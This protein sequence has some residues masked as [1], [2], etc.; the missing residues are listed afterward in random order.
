MVDVVK[1]KMQ[2]FMSHFDTEINVTE[3][4]SN[5]C[6]YNDSGKSA[7]LK[8]L[9]ILM[10][11][12]YPTNQGKFIKFGHD[13]FKISVDFTTGVTISKTKFINGQNLWEM[14]QNGNMIYT[15]RVN[16]AIVAVSGVPK[17]IADYWGVMKDETTQELLNV[18]TKHDKLFLVS[19][20]GGDNYKVLTSK[21][22]SDLLAKT[23]KALNVDRLEKQGQYTRLLTA[24]DLKK[25]DKLAYE[26]KIVSLNVVEQLKGKSIKLRQSKSKLISISNTLA[27]CQK[28]QSIKVHPNL[29]LTDSNRVKR[30]LSL[31]RLNETCKQ[32][33]W[34]E[35]QGISK[36]RSEKLKRC[37]E[38]KARMDV[39]FAPAC[40]PVTGVEKLEKLKKCVGLKDRM[41]VAVHGSC[42]LVSNAE[43]F[44]K[45]RKLVEAY[46]K[47]VM[48]NQD[49][50][51]CVNELAL[52]TEERDKLVKTHGLKV[53]GNCGG[54]VG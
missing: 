43:K 24:L 52:V 11:D 6:G 44:S 9:E 51:T 30:I 36:S 21:L 39:K 34:F 16:S 49:Y 8:A 41:A 53:C 3:S 18:R 25:A 47:A 12:S 32:K 22:S 19:T 35:L 17:P 2:G 37:L 42:D 7:G 38:L 10:F 54:F 5:F 23:T 45:V 28:F 26:K 14:S 27:Q 13:K 33:I 15:N 46:N 4:I 50:S 29:T 31:I 20:S 48:L 40:T 1:L